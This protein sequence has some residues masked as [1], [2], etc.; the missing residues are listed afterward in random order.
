[1]SG[2]SDFEAFVLAQDEWGVENAN[3]LEYTLLRPLAWDIGRKASPWTLTVPENE[4]FDITVLRG[5]SWLQSPHDRQLLPAAAVH[6]EL[7][8]RGYDR[9]FAAAEFRRAC[10]ARGVGPWRA[11]ALFFAVLGWTSRP[12]WMR[13][14]GNAV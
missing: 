3:E 10:R 7:L 14:K 5:L 6:D 4:N 13:K 9:P 8:K 2:F 12:N 1:M 11:W